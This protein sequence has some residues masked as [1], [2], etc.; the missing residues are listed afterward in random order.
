MVAK[1]KTTAT[2]KRTARKVVAKKQQSVPVRTQFLVATMSVLLLFTFALVVY[3]LDVRTETPQVTTPANY[4]DVTVQGKVT[5]LPVKDSVEV[6]PNLCQLGVHTDSGAFYAI[7]GSFEH[8]TDDT[9]TVKGTL[10]PAS[11]N[12]I[13]DYDGVIKV[14]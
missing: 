4:T 7:R 14:E 11:D 2:K 1:K 3:W 6:A 9:V 13:Y 8:E 5:C 12:T 10:S